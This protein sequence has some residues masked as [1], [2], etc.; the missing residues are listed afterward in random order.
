M[1]SAGKISTAGVIGMN[2]ATDGRQ[3]R[4]PQSLLPKSLPWPE[5]APSHRVSG[6]IPSPP[7]APRD[8]LPPPWPA[9]PTCCRHSSARPAGRLH[10]AAG[11]VPKTS[12]VK[13]TAESSWSAAV[14]PGPGAAPGHLTLSGVEGEVESSPVSFESA[15][16]LASAIGG[17]LEEILQLRRALIEREAELAAGVPLV[18][19]PEEPEH[20]ANRLEAVLRGGAQAVGCHAAALYLL[21]EA[22]SKLKL[23]SCW[24][25]PLDRLTAPPRPLKG[26]V[27]DLESMLGHAVVLGRRGDDAS[28]A[29][30][31][32][33]CRRRVR[34]H[35]H[36]HDD[37]RHAVDVLQ[38]PARFHRA[39]DEH[40]RSRRRPSG[41]RPGAGD[42]LAGGLCRRR[43]QEAD[44]RRRADA[45]EPI[46]DGRA[47][48]GPLGPGRLDRAGRRA[49][50]RFPR[51][52]LPARWTAGG[53]GGPCA[54]TAACRRLWPPAA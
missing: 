2:W 28:L 25:L 35:F 39:A 24:E 42:A 49:G 52:V 6:S 5:P 45:A 31:G 7:P 38:R 30:A 33:V 40:R 16:G 20:L 1:P 53:G 50:R 14:N 54:W 10:Y 3:D 48:L 8:P 41:R 13:S 29:G 34:A 15:R 4:A 17:M 9:Y 36:I 32:R 26:A 47:A 18:P 19:H 46:A 21:D 27:A 22:T 43:D 37:P 44:C 11:P 51:L 12:H 23:R